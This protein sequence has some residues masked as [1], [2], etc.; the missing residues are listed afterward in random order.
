MAGAAKKV[1]SAVVA[2]VLLGLLLMA[3]LQEADAGR[4]DPMCAIL[5]KSGLCK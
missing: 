4:D 3:G 1:S 2:L 5:H